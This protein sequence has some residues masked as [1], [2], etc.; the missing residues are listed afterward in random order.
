[1]VWG[2]SA[3]ILQSILLRETLV[4]FLVGEVSWGIVLFTWLAGVWGGALV[5][6]I[7]ARRT[8]RPE[9]WFAFTVVCFALSGPWVLVLVRGARAWMEIGSGQYLPV[10]DMFGLSSIVV[11]PYGFLI[12]LAFPVACRF[13]R[14]SNE[15]G[16]IGWVYWTESAGSLIGGLAFSLL[17]VGRVGAMTVSFGSGACLLVSLALWLRAIESKRLFRGAVVV[18]MTL[19]GVVMAV[20]VLRGWA[21]RLDHWSAERR[22]KDCA[23]GRVW[24]GAIESRYQRLEL[25]Q[26]EGQYEVYSN[27]RVTGVFPEP[28]VFRWPVQ[29]A[30]CQHPRPRRVL[31]LG[32][33]AEGIISEILTQPRIE[34]VDYVELDPAVLRL[35]RPYLDDRNRRALDDPRVHVIHEDARGYFHRASGFYDVVIGRLGEPVS[36]LAARF[37]TRDFYRLLKEKMSPDGVLA[38]ES[39]TSPA[40]LRPES[41]IATASIY[42]TLRAAFADVVVCWGAS[43][44][45]FSCGRPG[46]LTADPAE[47]GRRLIGRGVSPEYFAPGDFGITD[48]LDPERIGQRKRELEGIRGAVVSRDT[49]PAIYFIWLQRWEQQ[50]QDRSLRGL[51]AAEPA[52]DRTSYAFFAFLGSVRSAHVVMGV[53]VGMVFWLVGCVLHSGLRRGIAKGWV[54]WSIMTTGFMTLALEI[55]LLFAYQSLRGFAY[56]QISAVIGL[57][58]FGLVVG[59]GLAN[60]LIRTGRAGIGGLVGVDLGLV[61]LAIGTGFVLKVLEQRGSPV[62][63][64]VAVYSVIGTSGILGGAAFPWAASVYRSVENRPDRTASSI[65]A[66]D[67]FGACLGACFTGILLVPVMGIPT[68]LAGLAGIKSVSV[69]GL[70]GLWRFSGRR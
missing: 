50:L 67:H 61:L 33:G 34:S 32:G 37:Y 3:V 42:R 64:S 65:E 7:V 1:M 26:R 16:D 23:P 36:A 52:E 46:V 55:V 40:E 60:R 69:V 68:T 53:L 54:L 18:V 9:G 39:E 56:E 17:L 48:Q 58:M 20:G 51:G 13:L 57:F 21:N 66:A 49:Y 15:A 30:L 44:W 62:W 5:G 45:V 14:S 22:F 27:G 59:S 28:S 41:A 70:L 19:T 35:I 29:V 11:L 24:V 6:G 38:F 63:V 2:A 10:G 8:S 4:L 12:G 25:A 43:P 47:L 31:L